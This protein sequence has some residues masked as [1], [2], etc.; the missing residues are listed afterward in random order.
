METEKQNV[1]LGA[2]I[3]QRRI[4]RNMTQEE[5]GGKLYSASQISRIESGQSFPDYDKL[6]RLLQA[7][8]LEDDLFYGLRNQAKMKI[9]VLQEEALMSCINF[10]HAAGETRRVIRN[11][12]MEKLQELEAMISDSDHLTQQFIIHC[13]IMLKKE[14]GVPYPPKE[15]LS[16]LLKAIRLT[17]PRF[18]IEKINDSLYYF[19]EVKIINQIALAY[20]HDGDHET[21]NDIFRQLLKYIETHYQDIRRSAG[22]FPLVAHNYARELGLSGRYKEAIKIGAKG[23]AISIKHR[24]YNFLGGILHT[25]AE[26]YH[27]LGNDAISKDLFNLAYNFYLIVDDQPDK[28]IIKADAKRCLD[29]DFKDQASLSFSDG[30]FPSSASGMEQGDSAPSLSDFW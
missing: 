29:M 10:E 5:L 12:A 2:L 22:Y 8:G 15:E 11:T 14:D 23:W 19:N 18:D 4:D 6:Q 26:C 3:R 25:M 28:V 21:A 7:L 9:T 30:T 27:Y 13:K 1:L 16:L 24:H 20:S 17:V